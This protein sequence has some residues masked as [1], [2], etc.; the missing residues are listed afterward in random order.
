MAPNKNLNIDIQPPRQSEV[1]PKTEP[2]P[3]VEFENKKKAEPAPEVEFGNE[4]KS[5]NLATGIKLKL[6]ELFVGAPTDR[7]N[8]DNERY[9]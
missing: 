9:T 7:R 5:T 3:E 6:K 2:A 8:Y 4:R 1:P